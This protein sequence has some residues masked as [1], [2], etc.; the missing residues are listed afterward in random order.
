MDMLDLKG[1]TVV[2]TG[3]AGNLG[4][5]V[6]RAFLHAGCRLV[7]TDRRTG[8]LPRLYPKLVDSPN[9]LLATDV[10]ST[11]ADAVESVVKTAMQRF[12]RID[13]L[14]NTVGG[15][16]AGKRVQETS[17]EAWDAS[18][19][20]NARTAFIASR[21]VIPAMLEQGSGRIIHVAARTALEGTS[22]QLVHS[23]A[24][25]A[26]I[27]LTE[28]LS[29]ELKRSGINVNCILPNTIDTPQNRESMPKG[30]VDRWV[31]PEAIADV[32]LFLAS[33]AARAV[34]G[35]AIPVYGKG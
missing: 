19:D 15:Y 13:V 23:V 32:F 16:L 29:A 14:A 1:K 6:A 31:K 3:A 11:D 12:A 33:D 2:V 9:H 26:V 10:D 18:L 30:K 34:T 22:R 17:L 7:L 27:R 4:Q 24:K 5:A 25:S 21:A 8:R 35:A 20:L 28:T